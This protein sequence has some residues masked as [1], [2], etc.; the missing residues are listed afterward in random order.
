MLSDD[1]LRQLHGELLAT[2]QKLN[3]GNTVSLDALSKTLRETERKLREQHQGR[4]VDFHVVVKD[5]KPV[6]KPVVRK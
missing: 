4:S 2:K 5:G 3:Q 6:V 1:R